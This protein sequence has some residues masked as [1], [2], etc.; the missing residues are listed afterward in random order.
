MSEVTNL[1]FTSRST[2]SRTCARSG[3]DVN[4]PA[5]TSTEF[6]VRKSSFNITGSESDVNR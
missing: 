5:M 3:L 6:A 4:G 1:G 2:S